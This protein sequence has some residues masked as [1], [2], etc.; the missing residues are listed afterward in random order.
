MSACGVLAGEI[1]EN[2]YYYET[3]NNQ[4]KKQQGE[5]GAMKGK[6][7]RKTQSIYLPPIIRHV[8]N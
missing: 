7:D 5:Q 2:L 6:K 4:E 1:T 3:S 8:F